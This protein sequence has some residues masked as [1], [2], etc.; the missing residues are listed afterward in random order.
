MW[1][2]MSKYFKKS[3][4]ASLVAVSVLAL[5]SL[6]HARS[7]AVSNQKASVKKSAFKPSSRKKAALRMKAARPTQ[8]SFGQKAGLHGLSDELSLKSSVAYVVDQDTQEVLFSKNDNAVL[9][10][11]SITKLMTGVVIRESNLPMD[12]P[13]TI[14]TEDIDTE[15]GQ[16]FSIA[17]R[18]H[19]DTWRNVAFGSHVK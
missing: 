12:E 11:A 10:I 19:V 8:P 4:I 18:H 17:T 3:M 15:K 7:E 1:D 9:P 16:Q 13:I 6:G 14:T 5:P 2:S